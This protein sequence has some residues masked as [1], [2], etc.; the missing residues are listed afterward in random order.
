MPT[1][2]TNRLNR[3]FDL[4]IT[5]FLVYV[6]SRQLLFLSHAIM[7]VAIRPVRIIAAIAA[8]QAS[9][10][11]LHILVIGLILILLTVAVVM[12]Q[13]LVPVNGAK[14]LIIASVEFASYNLRLPTVFCCLVMTNRKRNNIEDFTFSILVLDKKLSSMGFPVDYD[15][16]KKHVRRLIGFLIF[17]IVLQQIAFCTQGKSLLI[18]RHPS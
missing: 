15:D 6:F 8:L 12:R 9:K 3:I 18:H 14:G 2:T 5:V 13:L 11:K 1:I 4:K 16:I 7:E 10:N 17:K